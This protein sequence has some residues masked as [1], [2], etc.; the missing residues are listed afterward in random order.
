MREQQAA[1]EHYQQL[2]HE[3]SLR[4]ARERLHQQM[5]E[6]AVG[7]NPN[8]PNPPAPTVAP[9]SAFA[10]PVYNSSPSHS[11]SNPTPPPAPPAPTPT[12]TPT[13]LQPTGTVSSATSLPSS[14][15]AHTFDP[16]AS[17]LT[18]MQQMSLPDLAYTPSS[19]SNSLTLQLDSID[20]STLVNQPQQLSSITASTPQTSTSSGSPVTS[21]TPGSVAG[22][23][24]PIR[25]SR[26]R[27][28]S[29]SGSR[30]RAASGSGYQSLLESRSRAASS[31]SSI[32][33]PFERDEEDEMDDYEGGLGAGGLGVG[34]F[35][36]DPE[37]AGSGATPA[38]G[39][40]GGTSSQM[41]AASAGVDPESK[42]KMDPVFLEFL[43]DICSNRTSSF[44]FCA[45]LPVCS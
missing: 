29:Q 39:A 27:A 35:E 33:H 31:A 25:P 34:D 12:P 9:S 5:Q 13:Q 23:S 22:S 6:G 43:A 41:G 20:P 7:P 26:S 17:D 15:F 19:N 37:Y 18:L 28:A 24:G 14:A 36:I 38:H 40:R 42:A 21:N 45:L 1:A 10:Q 2:L 3:E 16:S 44:L 11:Q 30:S 4:L 8:L 32:F